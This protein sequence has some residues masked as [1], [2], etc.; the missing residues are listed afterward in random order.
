MLDLTR[1]EKIILIFLTLSF[2]SGLGVAGYKKSRQKLELNFKP[3]EAASVQLA[4]KVDRQDEPVNINSLKPNELT[5]LPGIGEKLARRIADYRQ[6]HGPFE[7][8]EELM[9]VD[10][11]GQK[12]FE[13]IKNRISLF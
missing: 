1:Q 4:D 2:M 11:I 12:K 7:N 6:R 8:K 13:Q 9:R 3:Y 5:S 10:G